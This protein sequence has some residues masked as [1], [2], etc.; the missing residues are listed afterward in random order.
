MAPIDARDARDDVAAPHSIIRRVLA[1]A[2]SP[3]SRARDDERASFSTSRQHQD[4]AT[5][6]KTTRTTGEA[7]ST[8][9]TTR[10]TS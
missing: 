6:L 3:A 1:A 2:S 8:G 4:S 7:T 5:A 9:S 10:A